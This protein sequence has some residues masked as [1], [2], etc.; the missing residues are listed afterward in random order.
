M[1]PTVAGSADLMTERL[2]R[3][4]Q[5]AYI[6]D[7]VSSRVQTEPEAGATRRGFVAGAAAGAAAQLLWPTGSALARTTPAARC[8]GRPPGVRRSALAVSPDGRTVWT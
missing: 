3:R 2:T 7:T 5:A 8:A 6:G 1:T 4:H